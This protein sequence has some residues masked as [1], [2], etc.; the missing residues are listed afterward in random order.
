MLSHVGVRQ[1]LISLLRHSA[2]S[3]FQIEQMTQNSRPGSNFAAPEFL[4]HF[5]SSSVSRNGWI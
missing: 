1:K 5:L 4:F 2:A 3:R